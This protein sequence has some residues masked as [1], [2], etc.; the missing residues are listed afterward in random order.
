MRAC[1]PHA[2]D[3]PDPQR[4]RRRPPQAQDSRSQ[5]GG[6]VVGIAR[7]GGP[8]PCR[9]ADAGGTARATALQTTRESPHAG[10]NHHPPGAR[11]AV[12]VAD[13]SAVVDLLL[14]G[15]TAAHISARLLD[16]A[17]TVHVPHLLDVEVAQ[18]LRRYTLSG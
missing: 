1:S 12:I 5:G 16:P 18:A 4:L 11:P 10:R 9:A 3:D 14:G 6:H 13:A 17:E 2:T 15:D 8:A 7:A